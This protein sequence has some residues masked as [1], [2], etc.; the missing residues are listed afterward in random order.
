VKHTLLP[1]ISICILLLAVITGCSTLDPNYDPP[2]VSIEGLRS[3]PTQSGAP[4][5]EITLRVINPNQQPLDIAG[6]SYSL[7]ILDKELVYGVTKNVPLVAGYSEQLVT[8]EAGVQLIQLVRF[9]ASL[10]ATET[11]VLDYRLSAKIDF[12]GFTATQRL[13][14][15]GQISLK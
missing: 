14:E 15:T 4:R 9:L 10:G 5:F 2:R 8:L 11:D 3:V 1:R 7:E 12:H 13:E 6:I